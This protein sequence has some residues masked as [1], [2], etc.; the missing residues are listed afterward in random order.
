MKDD[1]DQKLLHSREEGAT[2]KEA[3]V[4]D[5]MR[6]VK[7]AKSR[8]TFEQILR[9]TNVTRK[10]TFVMRLRK[11][12]HKLR[13]LPVAAA[14]LIV[15]G[16]TGTVGATAFLALK[17]IVPKVTITNI[18]QSNDEGKKQYTVDSQCGEFYSGKDLKYELAKYSNL[19]DADVLKVFQSTCEYNTLKSFFDTRFLSDNDET[20]MAKKKP[21]D[22]VTIYDSSNTFAGS[23]LANPVF[24]I[25]I[26]KVTAIG[27]EQITLSLK[28][29]LVDSPA[30]PWQEYFPEG[31]EFTRTLNIASNVEVFENGQQINLSK[32]VLGD[33]V[34]IVTRSVYEVQYYED[35][36][37]NGLGPLITFEVAGM[38]RSGLDTTYISDEGRM[39]DP[40]IV[41]A[42]A[43]LYPCEELPEYSC[44]LVPKQ[45]MGEVYAVEESATREGKNWQYFR[46]DADSENEKIKSYRLSGRITSINGNRI[47]FQTRGKQEQAIVELPYDAV[48]EYNQSTASNN[49]GAIQS[50]KVEVGDLVEAIYSQTEDEDHLTLKSSDI[51]HFMV[52]LQT[53]PDGSYRKY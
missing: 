49:I 35:S 21:G 39:G 34:Q 40:R 53:Q 3:F 5:T 36:K 25:T 45:V 27:S 20:S 11:L 47:T 7:S 13:Q 28:L 22:T 44:V 9:K 24:G 8:E 42:L 2:D 32:V 31:K 4:Q 18:D 51:S 1:L 29:Y 30:E 19:S 52:I 50:L 23:T 43:M 41:D 33:T 17:W 38:V 6:A 48:N 16:L 12:D 26:G 14:V 10:E 15:L 37:L 46:K